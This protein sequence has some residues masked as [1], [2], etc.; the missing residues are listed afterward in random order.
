MT[1]ERDAWLAL[2]VEEVLEPELAICDPHH[3]LWDRP[4]SRYLLD[5]L[6]ADTR[7]GGHNITETVFVE[8][9]A[10][11]RKDGPAAMASVGEVEFVQGVAAQSASG[12]YGDAR[13]AAGII[14]FA[15]L[16]A[17]SAVSEVL[18]AH[19]SASRDRFRG[20]RHASVWDASPELTSYKKPPEGLLGD[21]KFREGIA[22]LG[23]LGLSYEA[24]LYHTQLAELV[25]L[26]NAF[27]NVPI[28]LD[29]IGGPIGIGPYEGKND[30]VMSSWKA[31]ITA[32]A[33]CPNVVVKLGGF[34]MPLGGFGWHERE[35]P[36][37]SAELAATM[38]PWYLHCIEAF[39]VDRCM[40]ESNFPVDKQSVSYTV[41]W[42]TFKRMAEG[43]SADEKAA[44]F[45]GTALRTY[46][47]GG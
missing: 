1:S 30:E 36:A 29:H 35:R 37:G 40:F 31:G 17:G 22:A 2:T 5:E 10:M 14:G 38:G 9:S 28:V 42:N 24:W 8:C 45:R 46:R 25:D 16:S 44:L 7:G 43:F 18:E 34:G 47:I 41:L 21:T 26:A 33:A 20:I 15:D 6:L 13:L 23:N 32:V 11:Y 3:H 12:N 19:I 39:G 27:P 4:D